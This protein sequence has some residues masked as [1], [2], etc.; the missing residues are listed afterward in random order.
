MDNNNLSDKELI[1]GYKH[2]NDFIKEIEDLEKK[3][4]E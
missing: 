2:I 3:E 1:M 4:S